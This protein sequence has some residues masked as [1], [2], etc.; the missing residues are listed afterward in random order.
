MKMPPR[1]PQ[2]QYEVGARPD[3]AGTRPDE[4][5][6]RPNEAGARPDEA[7]PYKHPEVDQ[8]T[9]YEVDQARIDV[10]ILQVS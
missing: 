7:G 9:P 2:L 6:A 3:E 1:L 5:G 8:G 10:S 4:A